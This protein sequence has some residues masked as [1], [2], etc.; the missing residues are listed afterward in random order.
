MAYQGRGD[1]LAVNGQEEQAL[2]D[3]T[4]AIQLA[5]R[6]PVLYLRR[7]AA[8]QRLGRV[9]EARQDFQQVLALK[10]KSHLRR[11]AEALLGEEPMN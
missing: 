1:A 7:G 3:Y 10:A 6:Q 2:E 4:Q 11:R 5:P 9:E 8:Y